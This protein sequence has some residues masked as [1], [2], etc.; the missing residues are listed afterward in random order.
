MRSAI[1][2]ILVSLLAGCAGEPKHPKWS[3]ATGAEQHERLMWQA[4]RDKDWS[5]F[6]RRLSPTF[7]G[8]NAD[9]QTLDRAG[10]LALWKGVQ[11]KEVVLGD[12]L[13]Q[14][15]GADMK[16]TY[17]IHF[18]ASGSA[19]SEPAGLR[20]LSVWQQAKRGWMLTAT[21]ITPIRSN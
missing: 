14:P 5:N 1:M 16:M 11:V 2:V 12:F 7:I 10:W 13:V 6:E 19:L 9:G 20:V 8:V 4:V 17:V 21:S 3:N 15:E 18:Q